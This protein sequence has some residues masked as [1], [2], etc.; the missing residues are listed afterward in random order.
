[1]TK[2]SKVLVIIG[3]LLVA[4]IA[5]CV[6][7]LYLVDSLSHLLYPGSK[8]SLRQQEAIWVLQQAIE[9]NQPINSVDE[10]DQF[11][12]RAGIDPNNGSIVRDE[13]GRKMLFKYVERTDTSITGSLWTTDPDGY[14]LGHMF[15][16]T[17]ETSNQTEWVGRDRWF[18]S[19]LGEDPWVDEEPVALSEWTKLRRPN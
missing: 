3:A 14:L 8:T 10:L 7:S 2:P 15:S 6:G 19:Q 12:S 9:Q 5:T 1:M 17:R 11:R 4:G 16:F 13:W 18:S